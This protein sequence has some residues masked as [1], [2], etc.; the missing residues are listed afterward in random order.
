MLPFP[1]TFQSTQDWIWRTS[2]TWIMFTTA[3]SVSGSTTRLCQSGQ[4][5][6]FQV[7]VLTL[8]HLGSK[9]WQIS[10]SRWISDAKTDWIPAR[11]W[12]QSLLGGYLHRLHEAIKRGALSPV[13]CGTLHKSSEGRGGT[14]PTYASSLNFIFSIVRI[15]TNILFFLTL[16]EKVVHVFWPRHHCGPNLAHSGCF[17][18]NCSAL[19]EH[20]HL[21]VVWGEKPSGEAHPHPW[22]FPICHQVKVSYKNTTDTAFPLTLPGCTELCPIDKFIGDKM[23]QY[24]KLSLWL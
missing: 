22:T 2:S 6:S 7:P 11:D 23:T 3:C 9:A 10:V 24:L 8:G 16:G 19:R 21:W 4:R 20:D 1:G 18:W 5:R 15:V 14:Q 17:Q 12:T 13:T